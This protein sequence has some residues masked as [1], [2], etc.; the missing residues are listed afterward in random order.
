MLI[1]SLARAAAAATFCVALAGCASTFTTVAPRP[2]EQYKVLGQATGTAC[3]SIGVL[4]TAYNAIP[5]GLNGRVERAY[6]AAIA[7]VPGA[8]ALV[9]VTYS[10]DWYWWFIGTARCVTVT[11]EAI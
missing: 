4:A 11:G 3:G 6:A 1:R 8:T 9:N 10:E 2:P 5:M 7:S